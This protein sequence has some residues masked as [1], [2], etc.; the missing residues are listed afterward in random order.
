ML[1]RNNASYIS[2][3]LEIFTEHLV[4]KYARRQKKQKHF[5]MFHIL[6]TAMYMSRLLYVYL[7]RKFIRREGPQ[8]KN[9]CRYSLYGVLSNMK[10]FPTIVSA[11]CETVI[12]YYSSLVHYLNESIFQDILNNGDNSDASYY[13]ILPLQRRG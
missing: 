6:L 8:E 3:F 10:Q 4:M 13:R 5:I 1:Q 2:I 9:V 12:S 7:I 11:S